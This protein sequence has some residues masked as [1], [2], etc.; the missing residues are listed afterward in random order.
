MTFKNVDVKSMAAALTGKPEHTVST[1][2]D[3]KF[4]LKKNFIPKQKRSILLPEQRKQTLSP[5]QQN[6]ASRAYGGQR[7]SAKADNDMYPHALLQFWQ[8][9]ADLPNIQNVSSKKFEGEFPF[10]LSPKFDAFKQSVMQTKITVHGDLF[11][12]SPER[13]PEGEAAF[14]NRVEAERQAVT[15][16]KHKVHPTDPA[17]VSTQISS[18]PDVLERISKKVLRELG[19]LNQ[20]DPIGQ[21]TRNN[22]QRGQTGVEEYEGYPA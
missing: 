6:V 1:E 14:L 7:N 3:H 21:R 12:D 10:V 11:E 17:L 8:N 13:G 15:G 20:G 18:L 5:Y 19:A 4:I 9:S 22:E 16:Q 2:M